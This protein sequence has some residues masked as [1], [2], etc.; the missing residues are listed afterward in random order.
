[1]SD[2]VLKNKIGY[3]LSK[4]LP[5]NT[6]LSMPL[7]NGAKIFVRAR[8]A[9]RMIF[10]EIFIEEIY[11]KHNIE[12]EEGD[13]VVDIGA[14]VGLFSVYA[15]YKVGKGK[16]F[17]FEPFKE[18]Y[19]ILSKQI[20]LND[21]TNLFPHNLGVSSITG[22]QTLF[23]SPTNTGGHSIKFDQGASSVIIKT[24]TLSEFCNSNNISRIDFLKIDCEG[25]EFE[26]LESS[27]QILDS[28]KKLVMECHPYKNKSVEDM[29]ELLEKH[30]FKVI[31]EDC[32][33]ENIKMLYAF[34]QQLL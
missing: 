25:S 2:Q 7:M 14:N 11:N 17:A 32:N 31:E 4:I 16:V 23:L 30:H 24:I 3:H 8:T 20:Q 12:I 5:R 10:K 27:P 15:S 28:V 19:E 34:N 9:D 1:M 22:E 13:T 33:H 29:I 21:L 6:I 18:N 26:I